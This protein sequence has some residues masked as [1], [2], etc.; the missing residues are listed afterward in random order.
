M[1]S[2]P[3]SLNFRS[4]CAWDNEGVASVYSISSANIF[5]SFSG[6]YESSTAGVKA[7]LSSSTSLSNSGIK[8]VR[9]IYRCICLALSSAVSAIFSSV[10]DFV[11][12]WHE[13]FHPTWDEVVSEYCHFCYLWASCPQGF[14]TICWEKWIAI[15]H[16]NNQ[17]KLL[18]CF[19]FFVYGKLNFYANCAEVSK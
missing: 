2:L 15:H 4:R 18:P 19:H 6:R 16:I 3:C 9:R 14:P 5:C 17:G 11:P 8:Y 10:L 13:V 1:D 7:I 12:S